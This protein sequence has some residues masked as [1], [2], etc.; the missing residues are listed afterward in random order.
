ME[1]VKPFIT[2]GKSVN[3]KSLF[4]YF[5]SGKVL[6]IDLK[7]WDNKKKIILQLMDGCEED[8]VDT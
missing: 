5:F 1:K 7:Y 8:N 2:L 4:S 3:L 6:G